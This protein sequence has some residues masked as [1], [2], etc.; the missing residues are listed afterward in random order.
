M[1]SSSDGSGVGSRVHGVFAPGGLTANATH[2]Y[3]LSGGEQL[4]R[5][6]L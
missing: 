2:L 5:I 1:W 4:L 6:P 3:F